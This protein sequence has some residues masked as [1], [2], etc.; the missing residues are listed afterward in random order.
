MELAKSDPAGSTNGQTG[1]KM[2]SVLQVERRVRTLELRAPRSPIVRI[3]EIETV[4]PV[5]ASAD[6][7]GTHS[8]AENYAVFVAP[9]RLHGLIQVKQACA[10]VNTTVSSP[11]QGFGLAI[12][13]HSR[14]VYD[15]NDPKLKLEPYRL[16]LVANLGTGSHLATTPGRLNLSLNREVE[17]DPRAGEYFV[18]YQTTE[19]GEWLCPG[20]SLGSYVS[21][22]GR[23]TGF[24]G[25]HAGDFPDT[26][27]VTPETASVPW[28]ALRSS[29]GVRLYGD[30]A[31]YD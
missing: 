12:Y 31:N 30:V 9:I 2:I 11:A 4:P 5:G 10:A 20:H 6:F 3:H 18:A 14:G 16:A 15:P 26:L 25:D 22:R 8:A 24:L 7:I 27:S 13:K 29:L 23:K 17:L 1:S 28:V 19:Y 21:R